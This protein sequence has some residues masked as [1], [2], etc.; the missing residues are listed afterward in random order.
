MNKYGANVKNITMQLP[1]VVHVAVFE[2]PS[3]ALV[4]HLSVT[5]YRTKQVNK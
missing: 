1:P 3:V 2:P 5:L 4:P